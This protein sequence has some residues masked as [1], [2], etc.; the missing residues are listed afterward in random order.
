MALP[1]QNDSSST[2]T[3]SHHGFTLVELLVVIGIIGVLVGLIVPAVQ[4]A[5]ESARRSSCTN[6][7]RQLA[8]A[9]QGY[10]SAGRRFPPS[11]LHTPGTTFVSNNGSWSIHGRL[12]PH[13]EETAL[14]AGIN[15][16]QAWD[17]GF[18]TGTPD[19]ARN[20]A[21]VRSARIASFTCPSERQPQARTKSGV[22]FVY[23]HTYGFN[24]G[25]W[26]VYDPQTG[27]GGDGAFHPNSNFT[28]GRFTDGL[29]KTLCLAEVRAFTPYVRNTAD[30]G[31]SFP[32]DAPPTDP[33][34]IAALCTGAAAADVKL[35]PTVNDCTGHTE[36]PDGRVHHAGFTTV[37]TPNTRV[38]YPDA[39]GGYDIDFNSRQEGSNATA[40]TYA[41][42][43]SRSYH[44]GGVVTAMMD[45][46]VGLLADSIDRTVWRALGTRAGGETPAQP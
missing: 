24:A 16:E 22:T 28:A 29:S 46:S 12:L 34:A 33:A 8:L 41:A 42:I 36:W 9:V 18:T 20:W 14:A 1:L 35:G 7:A 30:P 19:S 27:A 10:A 4:S 11:M 23:P 13:L 15:L 31:P 43:T 21:Q 39:A 3:R 26:F 6:N 37:F 2:A 40:K 38:P 17:D 5:R 25:T 32:P 45:G 44:P